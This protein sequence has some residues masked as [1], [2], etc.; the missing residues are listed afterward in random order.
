M[1]TKS[2]IEILKLLKKGP[3]ILERF[4]TDLATPDCYRI[5]RHN[6]NIF[7]GTENMTL[8]VLAEKIE[9]DLGG[10]GKLVSGKNQARFKNIPLEFFEKIA[11]IFGISARVLLF[12]DLREKFLDMVKQLDQ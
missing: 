10:L 2:E 3:E 11:E 5:F 12:V 1:L 4:R 8:S 7:L 6:I 9:M